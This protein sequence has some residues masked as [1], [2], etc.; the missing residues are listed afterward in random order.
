MSGKRALLAASLAVCVVLS[1]CAQ[2]TAEA[3]SDFLLNEDVLNRFEICFA[4]VAEG[5]AGAYTLGELHALKDDLAY[6]YGKGEEDADK[7][8]LLFQEAADALA[9]A[10]AE[11]APENSDA[12]AQAREL[13]DEGWRISVRVR[14]GAYDE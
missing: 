1:A 9:D 6:G 3:Y 11:E 14:R 2:L 7:A 4:D 12:Y 5:R 10:V 13:F 8:T